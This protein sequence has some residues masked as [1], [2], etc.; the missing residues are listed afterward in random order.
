MAL[1]DSLFG[2]ALFAATAALLPVSFPVQM[3]VLGAVLCCVWAGVEGRILSTLPPPPTQPED[4]TVVSTTTFL[5]LGTFTASGSLGVGR[6]D[7]CWC[8]SGKK[9][10]RCHG[11]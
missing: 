6:N 1:L 7:P 5:D 4:R 2:L 3:I 9:F 8:D 10:K 11:A